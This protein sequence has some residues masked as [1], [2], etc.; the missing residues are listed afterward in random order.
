MAWFLPDLQRS[1]RVSFPTWTQ[2]FHYLRV[3]ADAP[4][5]LRHKLPCYAWMIH[6]L[7][8]NGKR[9]A[10]DVLVAAYFLSRSSQF[11]KRRYADSDR[12]A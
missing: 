3:I 8:W 12:W 11:R 2:F 4:L 10:K 9:M 5:P 1:G 7:G 6:W